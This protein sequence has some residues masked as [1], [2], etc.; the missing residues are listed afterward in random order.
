M[1]RNLP[2]GRRPF[3]GV[4][5]RA[6]VTGV[7][8]GFLPLLVLQVAVSLLVRK[9]VP[10]GAS[11]TDYPSAL[12][13]LA[14]ARFVAMSLGAYVAARASLDRNPLR[15]GVLA[16]M[17]LMLLAMVIGLIRPL[18]LAGAVDLLIATAIAIAAGW[19]GARAA[20]RRAAVA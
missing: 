20:T 7:A 16:A 3:T 14:L 11:L 12:L 19:W 4:N 2:A 15:H 9:T 13:M 1:P 17:I 5:T 6:L 18:G 10:A 8:F